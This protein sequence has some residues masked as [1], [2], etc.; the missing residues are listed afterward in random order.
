MDESGACL[1]T[2]SCSSM[3][4]PRTGIFCFCSSSCGASAATLKTWFTMGAN[5]VVHVVAD[6]QWMAPL[7]A[8]TGLVLRTKSSLVRFMDW[9]QSEILL[10]DSVE[11]CVGHMRSVIQFASMPS[12]LIYVSLSQYPDI[13]PNLFRGLSQYKYK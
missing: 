1:M 5:M 12:D 3:V 4:F 2:L 11:V 7:T 6:S 10:T 13:R 8:G 9:G